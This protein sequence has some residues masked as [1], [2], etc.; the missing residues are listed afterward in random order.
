VY[1]SKHTAYGEQ[2]MARG[3]GGKAKPPVHFEPL[4]RIT[5]VPADGGK[6]GLGPINRSLRLLPDPV[7][8]AQ[9]FIALFPIPGV[10][11]PPELQVALAKQA[12]WVVPAL[13]AGS[14]A[15]L[16]PG[17]MPRNPNGFFTTKHLFPD[18][19]TA[20]RRFWDCSAAREAKASCVFFGGRGCE[21]SWRGSASVGRARRQ[22][23]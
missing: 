21:N 16:W 7:R 6:E 11:F 14:F 15:M 18:G 23:G 9:A 19:Y 22:C 12:D 1:C 4:R 2:T 3:G 13:R 10:A 5:A 17:R 8:L 20:T